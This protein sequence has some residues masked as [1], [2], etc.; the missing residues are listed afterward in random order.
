MAR[1]ESVAVGGY[2]PTPQHLVPLIARHL[3]VS[4]SGGT[5]NYADP[6]AGD[7]AAVYGLRQAIGGAARVSTCELEAQRHAALLKRVELNHE[8][9]QRALRGDAFCIELTPGVGLLF[10]NPPYDIDPVHGRLEQRF[11]ERFTTSLCRG[12]VLVFIVPHYA[13][14]ASAETLALTFDDVQCFR[15]PKEDFAAFKQVV[16]FAKKAE[17]RLSPDADILARVKSWAKSAARCPILGSKEDTHTIPGYHDVPSWKLH[18]FDLR[19]LVSK[20]RPWKETRSKGVAGMLSSVPHVMP[21][22]PV[23]DLLFRTFTVAT[24]PRPAHIAAGIASGL[25]NGRSVSSTTKGM[26][27]LLVKGVFTREYVTVQENENSDGEVTSVTQ[28]QQPKLETTVLDLS[29]KRYSL[30]KPVGAPKTDVIS[31]MSIEGLLEHYGPSLMDV[32]AQQCPVIYDP[33]R[34]ADDLPLADVGRPLFRAHTH[35][36]KALLK[37]LGGPGLARAQRRGKAAILLG[38]IGSGKTATVLALANTIA[39]RTLVVCPPHLLDSWENETRTVLPDAEVRFLNDISDVDALLDIPADRPV[40]AVLSREDAKLGHGVE[41]VRYLGCCPKCGAPLPSGDLAKKR[42]RCEAKPL[43]LG[44]DLARASFALAIHAAPQA[45]NDGNVRALLLG[46][47]IGRYLAQLAGTKKGKRSEWAGFDTDWVLSTTHAVARRLHLRHDPRLARLL[48]ELLM[49]VYEPETIADLARAFA[50]TRDHYRQEMAQALTCLLPLGSELQREIQALT[51]KSNGGYNY[52]SFENDSKELREKGSLSHTGIGKILIKD[53][54]IKLNELEPGSLKLA[55]SILSQLVGVSDLPQSEKECGEH[56]YQA[57]PEPRRFPVAKYIARRYPQLFDFLLLDEG[58][59]Y[60]NGDTAQSHA[61]HRLTALGLPFVLVTGSLMNGY[62]ESLF[63]NMWAVSPDFRAEFKRD[64]KQKHNERYGYSK[65]ILSD[66][67]RET[68]EIVAFGTQTDRV[69]RSARTAG[70]SPG[71]LPLFLFRHLLKYSVTL[72]KADLALDLPKCHHITQE[73]EPSPKLLT[74]YKAIVSALK[75]QI[76]SDRF[77]KTG[78][79]GKLFGALAELPSYLDLATADVGN[80]DD[81]SYGIYYPKS[82]GGDLVVKANPISAKTILPKE[83]WMLDTVRAELAEG[84][85]VM[86]FTSHVALTPRLARLLRNELGIEV[87][88]LDADKVPTK[89]RQAWIDANVR[90]KGVRVMVTNP[91]VIQT[92]LN[93]LVHFSSEIWME[94]PMANPTV[95]R[96][97]VG[98]V[99]RVG[100]KRETRIYFPV[101]AGTLQVQLH[102]LLLRKVAVA[103]AC[104]GLD[105]ESMLLAAGAGEDAMLTG[106]SLGRQLWEMMMSV[107]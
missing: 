61:A 84:R 25:F 50:G 106:L 52:G 54:Q 85:N 77:S 87:A 10:L 93:N 79:S 76:T 9:A 82:V 42:S 37:V 62:A 98:R 86:V 23:Q 94:N 64:E 1:P 56:L 92:G 21:E 13:L 66:K 96:Q 17:A 97:A 100:A 27:D 101:Y 18:E 70:K 75:R 43:T 40:I 104:D 53:G 26:P 15:F 57:V 81:G 33:K 14:A 24:A 73:I 12:G 20:S 89:K 48:G 31:E 2:F 4:H 99:D 30:L 34:D 60:Q 103:T 55:I 3:S 29:T 102:E 78:L 63:T 49:A 72:H 83:Q 105:S 59:E 41:A 8:S 80:Q 32:M 95:F 107:N 91:V 44:D 90:R 28:V 5:P 47:H 68:R 65:R 45:P 22:I 71:I 69:E 67:D 11:L 58:H 7:G 74:N 38:E 88:V 39:K 35:A 19:G 46:R 6:C 51:Y 36:A 16:L